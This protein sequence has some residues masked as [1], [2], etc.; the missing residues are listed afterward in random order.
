M[1]NI[2]PLKYKRVLLKLSGEA[3]MGDKK[4]GI[5]ESVLEIYARQI[6][7]IQELGAQVGI[8]IGGGK[9]F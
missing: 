6:R 3:L 2:M 8:V 4:S 7:E 5:D 1:H 9:R